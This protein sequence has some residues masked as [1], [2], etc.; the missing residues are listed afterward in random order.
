MKS[1]RSR[2]G[3]GS[4]AT[5]GYATD[6]EPLQLSPVAADPSPLFRVPDAGEVLTL[7][8][9]PCAEMYFAELGLLSLRQYV[10]TEQLVNVLKGFNSGTFTRL[11]LKGPKGVGKSVALVALAQLCQKPCIIY[12]PEGYTSVFLS[13][14][15]E[16]SK[17]YDGK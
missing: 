6:M 2:E 4:T 13:Y 7:M 9:E 16:L 8:F 1:Q 5:D 14:L 17:K 3:C 12:S 11:V 15:E 10:V